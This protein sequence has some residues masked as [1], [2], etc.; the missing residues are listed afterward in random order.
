[1]KSFLPVALS[2]LAMS[3]MVVNAQE[4]NSSVAAANQNLAPSKLVSP[5]KV[6]SPAIAAAY[7]KLPL[8]FEANQGQ[9]D[10][11]VK[12]LSRGQGYSLFLT[13]NA[14]V[15]ALSKDLTSQ[16]KTAVI[17]G[18][19]ALRKPAMVKTDVVRMELAGAARGMQVS[20]GDPLPGKANYF[21]G[22]DSSK[23][24]TDVPT[25]TKVKYSNVYPGIDLVY[26]GN[27]RQLEYD[28]IVAP[29]A[30]PKRAR[31]HFAGASKLKLN[32]GGDLEIIA[33]DGEIAFHKPVVYQIRDGQHQQ[34][35]GSFQL[36]ADNIVGF[37]LGDYDRSRELVV[38]PVLAYS[39]YL[40]GTGNPFMSYDS[41]A[42]IG[43]DAAGNVYIA[44]YTVSTDF[45]AANG[46]APNPGHYS[47]SPRG[48]VTEFDPTL[49]T[50]VYSTYF[51]SDQTHPGG[52]QTLPAAL[53]VDGS[54][55]VY[56]TGETYSSHF[57]VTRGPFGVIETSENAF[58]SKLAAGGSTLVYSFLI[59]SSIPG[60]G[61]ITVDRHGSAYITGIYG[62]PFSTA[63][64][65]PTTPGAYLTSI[66]AADN[67]VGYAFVTK[68]NPEGTGFDYSTY[69]G[70]PQKS[71]MTYAGSTAGLAI[72]VN[73]AG[74]AYVAGRTSFVSF[75]TTP[76]AFQSVNKNILTSDGSNGF[77]T[78]L[79]AAGSGLIYST[80]LGGT[81]SGSGFLEPGDEIT[82]IALDHEGNAYVAGQATSHDFPVTPGALQTVNTSQ[83][84]Y[85]GFISK[86]NPTG[87]ALVYSTYLGGTATQL[88][89]MVTGTTIAALAI[90]D[91]KHVFVTGATGS[92]NF[93]V[94]PG[95]FQ[96]TTNVLPGS[97][98]ATNAFLSELSE[99]GSSLLY[100][101][102]LGG[103]PPPQ[104]YPAGDAATG[105]ALDGSG[106]AFIVGLASSVDFP[107]TSKAYQQEN[108]AGKT[109]HYAGQI[110]DFVT[111]FDLGRLPSASA[112]DTLLS[113]DNA[114]QLEGL[115][116]TFTAR[117]VAPDG[118]SI[119]AGTV[120][121]MVDGK[122]VKSVPLGLGG[123]AVYY[124]T[125][126]SVARHS[127]VASYQGSGVND[128]SDSGVTT[129]S[130]SGVVATPTFPQPGGT[131]N[132]P[133]KVVL[134]T[135]S[136]GAIIH[137]T[138][139]GALPTASSA[140]YSGPIIVSTTSTVKAMAVM[141]GKTMS[142]V[143]TATYSIVPSAVP[144]TTE[145]TSEF[146][147]S[148]LNESA[149][150]QASVTASSGATPTGTV[151]FKNGN[152]L[153]G[154]APLV[155]GVAKFTISNLTLYGHAIAAL[156]TGSATNVESGASLT[157][158]VVP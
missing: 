120:D 60:G 99:T 38:D 54:G 46:P 121:F 96:T 97:Y 113:A 100:S 9:S 154:T 23:W 98:Q 78:K 127:V 156:Y 104:D 138:T 31:L 122:T 86:M 11:Q 32:S 131:Y 141:S 8:S 136:P 26:Y 76:G 66:P 109:L 77:I 1:M 145:I 147:P 45:P 146:N 94:T 149:E 152:Q 79:N 44:G 91:S 10:P 118:Y 48:Y 53:F 40:G 84:L 101:T 35:E 12:F 5:M 15:L 13:D 7:G 67:N 71:Q 22:K 39:T 64:P 132:L 27:Q 148:A 111:R 82:T 14:A 90:D 134:E 18:K 33:K 95:A 2:L 158:V 140:T 107:V 42:G 49:S 41:V 47:T 69:L 153:L 68:I 128:P 123:Y 133:V 129:V 150:F 87:T 92:T 51:G 37:R 124:A 108:N 74:E 62:G 3:P 135:A 43:L 110:N 50:L 65:Y 30:D 88:T 63:G 72:A 137:F 20:G 73:D 89:G 126:L 80:Y 117:V 6:A 116:I 52:G 105:I 21:L 157:Q 102:Y 114:L 28:F 144:T 115:P 59:A 155:K 119:P 112:T 34:I 70:G 17:A 55:A 130:V 106:H 75:P 151:V 125:G 103:H 19:A 85:T 16:P 81:S 83:E 57:P 93:P 139:N 24:H 25:Y 4:L 143:A 56:L 29:H 58:V 36:L 61:A 142:A